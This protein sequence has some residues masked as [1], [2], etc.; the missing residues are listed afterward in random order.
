ME[1]D[2]DS[3]LFDPGPAGI[4]SRKVSCACRS[5]GSNVFPMVSLKPASGTR[6]VRR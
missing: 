6:L 1:G 2:V 4:S 5:E 3:L